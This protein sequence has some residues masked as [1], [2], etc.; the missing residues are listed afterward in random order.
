MQSF[1]NSLSIS[2]TFAFL[3][4]VER[5]IVTVTCNKNLRVTGTKSHPPP[6]QSSR[7]LPGYNLSKLSHIFCCWK[8]RM[9][10]GQ[11][12]FLSILDMRHDSERGHHLRR[13]NRK[14][15]GIRP[16]VHILRKLRCMCKR[17]ETDLIP[18][19]PPTGILPSECFGLLKICSVHPD[20]IWSVWQRFTH[21]PEKI[22]ERSISKF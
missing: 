20:S 10:T 1:K 21:D 2:H 5:N 3:I 15:S 17:R 13:I 19:P 18:P 16:T 7:H 14:K 8:K 22:N 9:C 11:E 4:V 12:C 6:C